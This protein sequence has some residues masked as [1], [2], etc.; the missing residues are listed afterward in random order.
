MS[1]DLDRLISA[2]IAA[3]GP[4]RFD[5]FMED[6]LF[7]PEHGYYS[8]GRAKIGRR[9]DFFTSVSVGAVYGK[10]LAAQLAEV[11][12][13]LDRPALFTI[14][15]QGGNDG[16]LALDILDALQTVYPEV[17]AASCYVLV[18][19]FAHL[20]AAQ[21]ERLTGLHGSHVHWQHTLD[22]LE[23]VVGVHLSNEYADAL[24]VRLFRRGGGRW[25][26]R[27]VTAADAAFSFADLDSK[28]LPAILP[29]G[30][31]DGY[32]AE[33]R[34]AATDWIRS[35]CRSIRR[36]MVLVADYGFPRDVMFAPW[37]VD[38]TLS[39]YVNHRRDS[40]PLENPGGKDITAHVDFTAL[41]EA[42][43]SLGFCATGFADQCHFLTGLLETLIS[44]S[45]RHGCAPLTARERQ[46]FLTL[47]HPEMMGTQFKF[48]MLARG[49]ECA[50]PLS[51]YRHAA[52]GVMKLRGDQSDVEA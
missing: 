46:A 20:V 17:Y 10:L 43:E 16:T 31:D 3:D 14:I 15:E 23:P 7:N 27:Y 1:S 9:G 22:Q 51:G 32:I 47:T 8:S 25:L 42:G 11:W 30:V 44:D 13:I 26:E 40:N 50:K 35:A 48:L 41:A 18:E 6:A 21:Q 2:A 28:D 36:G 12:Q 33:V 37:R 38:G 29:D 39:C 49:I 19:P 45:E 34:P 5:C 24:P 4:M 52:N